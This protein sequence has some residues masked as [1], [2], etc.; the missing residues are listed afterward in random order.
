MFFCV[1]EVFSFFRVGC[2]CFGFRLFLY[3]GFENYTEFS[4]AFFFVVSFYGIGFGYIGSG[5]LCL[6]G[7]VVEE[8]E[9]MKKFFVFN[10][11]LMRGL[12]GDREV[13]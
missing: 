5:F 13:I 9:S 8:R 6:I 4:I 11:L 10:E 3:K 2:F 12:G 1:I 7:G